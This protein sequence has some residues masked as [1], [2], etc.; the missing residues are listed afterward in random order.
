[1]EVACRVGVSVFPNPN[2]AA[3]AGPQPIIR[4][5]EGDRWGIPDDRPTELKRGRVRRRL[6]CTAPLALPTRPHSVSHPQISIFPP[7]CLS[8]CLSDVSHL[9]CT[10]PSSSRLLQHPNFCNL[11]P[12]HRPSRSLSTLCLRATLIAT[13][14]GFQGKKARSVFPASERVAASANRAACH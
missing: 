14:K 4:S 3:N 1:M 13:G 9:C 6:P 8:V 2:A 12:L 11:S 7:A 10:C 5:T